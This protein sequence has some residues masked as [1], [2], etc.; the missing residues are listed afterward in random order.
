M[1]QAWTVRIAC[2]V[3]S[4][5][6]IYVYLLAHTFNYLL[7]LVLTWTICNYIYIYVLW[8]WM[9]YLQHCKNTRWHDGADW[10]GNTW[11]LA[12]RPSLRHGR[13]A[14][15]CRT[16]FG[17]RQHP[18]Q[19]WGSTHFGDLALWPQWDFEMFIGY[20]GV[21]GILPTIWGFPEMKVPNNGWFIMENP[22]EMD[23]LGIPPF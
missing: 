18:L 7:L 6:S 23:D 10:R 17:S 9:A 5:W 22:I 19:L 15:R 12:F 4:R 20:L 1:N 14:Y 2:P 3:L 8:S 11:R 13:A 21:I 16:I